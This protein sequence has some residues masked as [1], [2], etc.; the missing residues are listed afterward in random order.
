MGDAL[1]SSARDEA[2]VPITFLVCSCSK[3]PWRTIACVQANADMVVA[4]GMGI[5]L[6][7]VVRVTVRKSYRHLRMPL[8]VLGSLGVGEQ[9]KTRVPTLA[10]QELKLR[11]VRKR[12]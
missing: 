10:R 9:L 5:L 3:G 11:R 7:L 12:H 6:S 1:P 8:I 2:L 4:M